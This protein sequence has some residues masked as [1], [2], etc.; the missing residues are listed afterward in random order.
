MPIYFRVPLIPPVSVRPESLIPLSQALSIKSWS[1]SIE[2]SLP[3]KC[4]CPGEWVL[5]MK[6][7]CSPLLSGSVFLDVSCHCTHHHLNVSIATEATFPS[8]LNNMLNFW[9]TKKNSGEGTVLLAELR[10]YRQDSR[11]FVGDSLDAVQLSAAAKSVDDR[12]LCA[13]LQL[14]P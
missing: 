11:R 13:M 4:S 5:W 6:E 9:M 14:H 7:T 12:D 8:H 10:Q 1:R 2:G 3:G